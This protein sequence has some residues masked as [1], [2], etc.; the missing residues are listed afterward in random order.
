MWHHG[1]EAI[2]QLPW[3]LP[4]RACPPIEFMSADQVETVHR[5]S[6]SILQNTGMHFFSHK[7]RAFL[8][9]VGSARVSGP[10]NRGDQFGN[11]CEPFIDAYVVQRDS[12]KSVDY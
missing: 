4:R 12:G 1:R 10:C 11:R 5:A 6:L 3:Q 2:L 7:A 9:H 8:D